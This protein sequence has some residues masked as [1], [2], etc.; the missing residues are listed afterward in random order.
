MKNYE[1]DN[2]KVNL[3]LNKFL[4]TVSLL[5]RHIYFIIDRLRLEA[6]LLDKEAVFIV[7]PLR[8]I[9]LAVELPGAAHAHHQLGGRVVD[10]KYERTLAAGA[11][12]SCIWRLEAIEDLADRSILRSG[13]VG[14]PWVAS[15]GVLTDRQP[16][17][18]T[19]SDLEVV[20]DGL[21]AEVVAVE[22]VGKVSLG[23]DVDLSEITL[24]TIKSSREL[25]EL[26]EPR[27]N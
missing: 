26:P 13:S 6:D 24:S 5:D 21:E 11:N 19:F 25:V 27:V 1:S 18:I 23:N 8:H 14:L 16:D 4:N 15:S 7:F 12:Q 17:L 3:W 9:Y 2:L 10:L 22:V 20:G